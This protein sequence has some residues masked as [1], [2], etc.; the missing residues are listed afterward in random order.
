M[1]RRMVD[2]PP[3]RFRLGSGVGD[4]SLDFCLAVGVDDIGP[5][6]AGPV[7]VAGKFIHKIL[8]SDRNVADDAL[9]IEDQRDV[10]GCGD[11]RPR[12]FR[13]DLA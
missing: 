6:L 9:L 8:F 3:P 4:Q 5:R 2:V 13:I 7:R 10:G 11:Q 12:G 1:R